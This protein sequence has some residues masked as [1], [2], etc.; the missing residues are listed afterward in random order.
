MTLDG[1]RVERDGGIVTVTLDRPARKNAISAAMTDGLLE[2]LSEV[3]GRAE[4]RVLV[5]TSTPPAFTSGADLSEAGKFPSLLSYMRRVGALVLAIHGLPK[6]TIAALPGAAVGVGAN[7]ALACDLVIAAE[8]ASLR[9]LFAARGL[10]L[11]GGGSWLL[12][13]LVGLQ[14]AKQLAFFA[15]E[16]SAW[17]AL[18]FGLVTRVVPDHEL[19]TATEEWAAR[20]AAG[21]S[22]ALSV[23]KAQLNGS[24]ERSLAEALEVEAVA[25]VANVMHPDFAE[26][27]AAF[28]EKRPAV[29]AS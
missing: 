28:R 24:F 4:D 10:S 9:E 26:G 14:R 20:L 23:I 21:P 8:G 22:Q 13:R 6:P 25:Q 19:D 11:D 17:D 16:I 15:D 7:L 29:F 2:T 12:P 3:A 27:L 1:L 18:A 5:L